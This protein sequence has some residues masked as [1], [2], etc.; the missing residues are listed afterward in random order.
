M[1]LD[2]VALSRA[3]L[4]LVWQKCRSDTLSAPTRSLSHTI[5]AWFST[6]TWPILLWR[7]QSVRQLI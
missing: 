7:N 1:K 6:H 3:Q 5:L 2:I 4:M